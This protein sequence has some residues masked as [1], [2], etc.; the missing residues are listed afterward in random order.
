MLSTQSGKK[1]TF[2]KLITDLDKSG[3]DKS[4]MDEKTN[5]TMESK[6]SKSS[7]IKQFEMKDNIDIIKEANKIMAERHKKGG[8]NG[9]K[10]KAKTQQ[11]IDNR[12]ICLKNYLIDLLKERRME[13]NDK[14]LAITKALK[15]SENKLEKDYKNF[16]RLM[17]DEKNKT[18]EKDGEYLAL[19]NSND[20]DKKKEKNLENDYNQ[21]K[22]ELERTVKVIQGSKFLAMFVHDVVETPFLF[23][24]NEE[25]AH[26]KDKEKDFEKLAGTL[27]QDFAKL[28]LDNYCP[29][30]IYDTTLFTGKFLELEEKVLKLMEKQDN[31]D[32]EYQSFQKTQQKEKDELEKR[33]AL[34]LDERNK[35]VKEKD[36][37]TRA[38]KAL[39]QLKHDDNCREYYDYILELY[40]I[41]DPGHKRARKKEESFNPACA[42][43]LLEKLR[44][45]EADVIKKI[46]K[47]EE[48][49]IE[50]YDKLKAKVTQRKEQNKKET[51]ELKQKEMKKRKFLY[52]K[53]HVYLI[54]QVY[55]Y[56]IHT[57]ISLNIE[58]DIN[59]KRAEERSHRIII[60]GRK[61]MN[62]NPIHKGQKKEKK[63]VNTK[64]NYDDSLLL[65]FDT[66]N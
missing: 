48:L 25:K 53:S 54:T 41:I 42:A 24:P 36:K 12:E 64:D 35:L 6:Q 44:E 37:E 32:K 33:D 62:R 60:K 55:N 50:E 10:V 21:I 63:R 11:I 66:D 56:Y 38:L 7:S 9:G 30:F 52:I 29:D 18:K 34:V 5:L 49:N 46:S 17:E 19:K 1:N 3:D 27:I 31:A 22:G 61:V 20:A 57:F 28:D 26:E 39:E 13:I 65:K 45:K 2:E 59:N 4:L 58:E 51:Q 15:E 16:L 14:E 23:R 8:E 43:K 40:D 47:L